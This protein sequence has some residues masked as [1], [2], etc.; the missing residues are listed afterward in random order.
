MPA[1][2]CSEVARV[3]QNAYSGPP[4]SHW[5]ARK[6]C[7]GLLGATGAP[8]RPAR[9]SSAATGA[10][11]MPARALH[12]CHRGV[13]SSCSGVPLGCTGTREGVQEHAQK[14]CS[15]KLCF[16]TQRSVSLCSG[17][18]YCAREDV[19]YHARK[20]CS[21]RLCSATL[22]SVTLCSGSLFSVH[23]Y[24]RVHTSIYIYIYT[25]IPYTPSILSVNRGLY[26]LQQL[27]LKL[28]NAVL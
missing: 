14:N 23:G 27:I 21:N 25:Y 28:I 16:A 18:L 9:A 22:P 17:S 2:A 26:I 11:K 5:D 6:A 19:Q 24:A 7:S 12:L 4:W 13:Q 20:N 10:L 8:K 15:K 1:R 3:A